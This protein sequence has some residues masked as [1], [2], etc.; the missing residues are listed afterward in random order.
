VPKFSLPELSVALTAA[1]A[2]TSASLA[3][4]AL[5]LVTS[6]QLVVPAPT[7]SQYPA[8]AADATS[9]STQLV[10]GGVYLSDLGLNSDSSGNVSLSWEFTPTT[11]YKITTQNAAKTSTY[12]S[13]WNVST[14]T[15]TGC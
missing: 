2:A 14:N 1:S 4:C 7:W 5:A 9:W 10:W 12:S 8:G 15:P 11:T 3:V 13:C 6:N